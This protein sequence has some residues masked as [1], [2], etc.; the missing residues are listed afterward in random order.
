MDIDIMQ[1]RW[2]SLDEKLDAAIRLDRSLVRHSVEQ[3]LREYARREIAFRIPGLI[4]NAV[5]VLWLGSFT[6]A[7]AAEPRFA[8]PA[9]MLLAFAVFLVATAVRHVVLVGSIDLAAPVVASQRLIEERRIARSRATVTILV[10]SPLLWTPLVVVGLALFGV[11]A[12]VTPG[13]PWLL[14]NV[15]VGLAAIPVGFALARRLAGRLP[16]HPFLQRIAD[17][18]AG[19]NLSAAAAWL[20]SLDSFEGRDEVR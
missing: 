3:R 17:D 4:L 18:L 10:L 13:I 7:H 11:D 6:A 14:A 8:L 15:A 1:E 5:A 2:K 16:G 9:L 19:R 20:R 12:Y